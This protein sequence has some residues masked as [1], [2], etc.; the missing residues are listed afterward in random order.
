MQHIRISADERAA[1]QPRARML[2]IVFLVPNGVEGRG[3]IGRLARYLTDEFAAVPADV[4]LRVLATRWSERRFLKHLSTLPALAAFAWFCAIGKAQIVHVNIAPRGS[5]Y[6]KLLFLWIAR[7]FGSKTVLHL[8]GSGYDQYFNGEIDFVQRAIRRHFRAADHVVVLG[9]YWKAFVAEAMGVSEERISVVY[10]GVPEPKSNAEQ[11]WNPPLI[12]S[13]GLVGERKGTDLLLEALAGLPRS[14]EWRAVIGG[15]GEVGKYRAMAEARNIS[16]KVKFLG[17]IEED[18]V[19]LWL[20]RAS[21][22]ALPSRAENQPVAILEA[23]A[24]A[25]PVVA[26]SIGAISEQVVDRQTGILVPPGEVAPLRT[27][28][29]KLLESPDERI[30]MGRAGRDYYRRHFSIHRCGEALRSLYHVVAADDDR[31]IETLER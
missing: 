24:R 16:D 10:N 12:V 15:N 20:N 23:M 6:R 19:D 31:A 2:Q 29:Q 4:K 28:L 8:H 14:L 7:L 9:R 26:T 13:M 22:F 3:G 17:W 25:V 21:I 5:T 1:A 27:G 18:Q 11:R 30:A